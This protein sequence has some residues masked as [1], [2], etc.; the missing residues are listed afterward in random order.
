MLAQLWV[1]CCHTH[2]T[3]VCV[4]LTHHHAAQYDEWQCAKRE[5]VCTK[6]CHDNNV[7][8]GFQ[9]T[10]GLQAHLVAQAVYDQCLLCL[11]QSYLWRNACK[12]HAAGRTGACSSLGTAYDDEVGFGF[13][14]TRSNGS[15]SALRY[16][17]HT[18][19]CCRVD[20]LQV[21]DEL[22]QVLNRVDVMMRRRR[23]E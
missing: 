22:C 19:G 5:F 20:V 6:H 17:F 11:C 10:V 14:Y 8:G 2:R 4:A 3:G 7:F 12:S 13:C 9:L 15:H 23:Y 16:E 21:E 18:H 1:L